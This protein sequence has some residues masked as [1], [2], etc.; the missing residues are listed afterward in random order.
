MNSVNLYKVLLCCFAFLVFKCLYLEYSIVIKCLYLENSYLGD[1][2][3]I[4]DLRP[5]NVQIVSWIYFIFCKEINFGP[6][7]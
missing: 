2:F 7:L 4:F 3:N 5:H 1:L 6:K